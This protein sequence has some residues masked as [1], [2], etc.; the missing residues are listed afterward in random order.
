MLLSGVFIVLGLTIFL[1]F[2]EQSKE[3]LQDDIKIIAANKKQ[4]LESFLTERNGDAETLAGEQFVIDA[5]LSV[6]DVSQSDLATSQAYRA[7]DQLGK[8]YGYHDVR[9]LDR[10]LNVKLALHQSAITPLERESLNQAIANRSPVLIDIHQAVD[11]IWSFGYTRPVYALNQRDAPVIGAVYLEVSVASTIDKILSVWPSN[12]NS[13]EL[14]LFEKK[15]NEIFYLSALRFEPASQRFKLSRPIETANLVASELLTTNSAALLDGVDYRGIRVLGAG[16]PITGTNWFLLA[17]TDYAEVILPM[18]ELVYSAIAGGVGVICAL[19]AFLTFYWRIKN[20]D[21]IVR[22]ASMDGRLMAA[23]RASLDGYLTIDAQGRIIEVNESLAKLSAFSAEELCN[24]YLYQLEVD[25]SDEKT[26]RKLEQIQASGSMRFRT[27]LKCKHGLVLD[28]EVSAV[29]V[30]DQ[31]VGIFNAFVHDIGAELASRKRM[32]RLNTFYRFTS[33]INI[34]IFNTKDPIQLL[35]KICQSATEDGGFVLA[36]AG[37]PDNKLGRIIPVAATGNA[38]AYVENLIVTLDPTLSTSHG[39]TRMCMLE[40]KIQFANDFNHDPRTSSWHE[41]AQK[42]DICASAAI[43]VLVN[44]EAIGVITFYANQ[45][46]YFDEEFRD[47]IEEVGRN[48][49]IGFQL[50][51]TEQ[52]RDREAM[53]RIESEQRFKRIFEASPLP[54]QIH[55]LST[56]KLL[57][58]NSVHEET[59]GY[60][61]AEIAD[62]ETWF[63]KVF[64][65]SDFRGKVK[66]LWEEN[67]AMAISDVSNRVIRS[68]EIQLRCKN[69]VDRTVCGFVSIDADDVIVQWLDLT[70]IRRVESELV[71]HESQIR[72]LLEQTITGIYVI[73]DD[74]I[75]YANARMGEIL[76]RTQSEMIGKDSIEVFDASPDAV[77]KIRHARSEFKAGTRQIAMNLSAMTRFGDAI[78][79]GTHASRGVWDGRM[80]IIVMAQDITERLHAEERISTYVKQLELSMQSTL[81]VV[82]KMVDMRDPYTAG[83]ERRV[84]LI[85][86]DIAREMGWAED[87]CKYLELAGLVHDIGKIAIPAEILSKPTRLTAIEYELIKSH[88][89]RGYEILK[90]AKFPIQI[91]EIIREHHERMDGSGYPQGLKGEQILP[92][93]RILAVADVVESMS[94]HRPYRPAM[95]IE[96]ALKEIREHR[97]TLFDDA[98]VDAMLRLVVEKKYCLPL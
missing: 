24:K 62:E 4:E 63:A 33:N 39:P 91:A 1:N 53:Q 86:S 74:R 31:G 21:A 28:V 42:Y 58:I 82:A 92:E 60:P 54:V 72:G 25:S 83:H 13:S 77:E 96:S 73:Q 40:K 12:S 38:S 20:A 76:G 61:L 95:G 5:I 2:A 29:F 78:I 6:N 69:G 8:T 15:N 55:S 37:F 67:L 98:V 89:E 75:V 10:S 18:R 36:W 7:I 3:K 79:L 51:E 87:Q 41:L 46:H 34:V 59:F 97:G 88:A 68:P 80:A 66:S 70:E 45:P 43:P 84:G 26:M 47:L 64:A 48:I 56:R 93:A 94:S 35:K 65:S 16:A 17:K 14:V 49:S 85:A 90:D 27:Q 50:S 81:E 57:A 52:Q 11:G 9:L 19:F 71:E 23:R 30:R 44:N 22:M 32:E